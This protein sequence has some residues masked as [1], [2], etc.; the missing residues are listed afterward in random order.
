MG[1]ACSHKQ[2]SLLTSHIARVYSTLAFQLFDRETALNCSPSWFSLP[3]SVFSPCPSPGVIWS[4]ICYSTFV[5]PR[6]PVV[7][8]HICPFEF[9]TAWQRIVTVSLLKGKR[10]T[11]ASSQSL[12]VRLLFSF[13]ELC[14]QYKVYY[15][16]KGLKMLQAS[17]LA[18]YSQSA[19]LWIKECVS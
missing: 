4:W 1:K 19:L 2:Q 5:F 7:V 6:K 15:R 9:T 18:C 11:F 14:C 17:S 8:G 12:S 13:N 3:I 10:V 16:C